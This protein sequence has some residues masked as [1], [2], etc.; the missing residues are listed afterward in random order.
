MFFKKNNFTKEKRCIFLCDLS[1]LDCNGF[2]SEIARTENQKILE[3]IKVRLDKK[4]D[5][6]FDRAKNLLN[7]RLTRISHIDKK[8]VD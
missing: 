8:E 2:L 5:S 4:K 3:D 6:S 7:R 1:E